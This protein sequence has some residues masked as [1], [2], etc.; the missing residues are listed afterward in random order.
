[1]H[2]NNEVGMVFP[3]A[4]L[5]RL[6]KDRAPKAHVHVD[7]V[8]MLGKA[9]LTWYATS[10]IDSA[11]F[12]AHKIGGYKGIGA[13]YLKSGRKLSL[14]MAGGGQER[15]RRPGTENIPGIIS[16]GLQCAKIC[17]QEPHLAASMAGV[18][19]ALIH[20]LKSIPG[21]VIHGQAAEMLPNTVHFHVEGVPGDDLLLNMDLSGIQAGNGSACSTGVA[22]P[23]HVMLALGYSEWVALNSVRISLSGSNTLQD[24]Q[25]ILEVIRQVCAR[26]KA[27][28]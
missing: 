5:A 11:S 6:I 16:F 27:H 19:E 25:A 24:V 22:R 20:G 3:V 8:Q 18:R 10:A 13:L 17:G 4:Q 15:G 23:S 26:L 21:V 14:F 9:D 28:Q 2:A 7:A 12:S 1:M